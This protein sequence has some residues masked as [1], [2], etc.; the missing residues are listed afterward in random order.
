MTVKTYIKNPVPVQAIKMTR[1]NIH[2]V[3]AFIHN[4]AV[5]DPYRKYPKSLWASYVA[6][7]CATGLRITA[8]GEGPNGEVLHIAQVGDYIIRGADGDCYPCAADVF[9]AMY[10]ETTSPVGH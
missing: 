2:E 9:E 3:Q 4:T 10:T 1:D 5:Y 6:T 8:M 7:V